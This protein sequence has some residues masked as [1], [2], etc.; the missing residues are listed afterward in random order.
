MGVGRAFK[1]KE[2][3][4]L[5][6]KPNEKYMLSLRVWAMGGHNSVDVAQE[7][8][9]AVLRSCACLDK[10]TQLSF[11][12][13]FPRGKVA[14]GVYIDDHLITQIVDKKR[15]GKAGRGRLGQIMQVKTEI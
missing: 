2:Y 9:E 3:P 4:H 7:T 13:P 5:G 11:G 12:K 8:H 14:E 15:C 1:G 10:R 6:L